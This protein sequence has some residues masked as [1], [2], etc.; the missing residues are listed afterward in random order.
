MS[1]RCVGAWLLG[2]L[3]AVG[4]FSA[5]AAR[6]QDATTQPA[7]ATTQ[8]VTT[9]PVTTQPA[10]TQPASTQ[11]SSATTKPAAKGKGGFWQGNYEGGSGTTLW[12][13]LASVLVILALGGAAMVV[14]KKYLPRLRAAGGRELAV[15]ETVHLG[16]RVTVHL[17]KA[18]GKRFMLGATRERV[19][20]LAEVGEAFP[21]IADLAERMDSEANPVVSEE[22]Q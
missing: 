5:D 10:A 21:D 1:T 14:T 13:M 4:V 15:L 18:G 16:P 12:T 3:A 2:L 19:S 9:Q 7:T 6:G 22:G 20:M 8:P 17:V 11:P